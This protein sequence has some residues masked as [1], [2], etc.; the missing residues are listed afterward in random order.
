V[1]HVDCKLPWSTKETPDNAST[2]G[3]LKIKECLLTINEANEATISHLSIIDKIRL[4]NQ[5]LGITRI[6]WTNS[7]FDD[8]LK[9]DN[10]KHSPF[11]KVYGACSTAFTVC[12]I[13]EPEMITI[14][15]L[16]YSGMF[17]ILKPNEPQYIAY[18]DKKLWADLEKTHAGYEFG[19]DEDD[20]QND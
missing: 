5:K 1:Q 15:V 20:D 19:D 11:R 12:D 13:L 14:L 8:I 9:A 6:I 3:S 2:K 17:R 4:R 16:K 18:D 7:S 10:I